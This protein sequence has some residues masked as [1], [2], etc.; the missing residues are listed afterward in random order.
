MTKYD[1]LAPESVI[2][3]LLALAAEQANGR[4]RRVRTLGEIEV[5]KKSWYRNRR[6]R[7]LAAADRS[8]AR[9]A[10]ANKAKGRGVSPAFG[11]GLVERLAAA[12]DPGAWYGRKDL[13]RLVGVPLGHGAKVSQVMEPRGIVRRAANPGWAPV[14][15]GELQAPRWVY[16]LT[17][18]GEAL[19]D[20]VRLIQ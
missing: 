19:R 11:D 20:A 8:K 4:G 9:Q 7:E 12:M 10:I 13:T 1:P 17:P 18:L 3:G 16:S 2:A 5:W 15:Y 14:R 6:K